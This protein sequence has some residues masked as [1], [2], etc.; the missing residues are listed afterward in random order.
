MILSEIIKNSNCKV[1]QGT[2]D[3]EIQAIQHHSGKI[4]KDTLFVA[5]SGYQR[6]GHDFIGQVITDGATAVVVEKSIDLNLIPDDVSVLEVADTKLALAEMANL[7]YQK[8]TEK[9]NVVGI[10]GTNGKTSITQMLNDLYKTTGQKNAVFGTIANFIGEEKIP[11][12]NTTPDALELARLMSE[13]VKMSCENCFMEVS[14]HALKMG[15]VHNMNFNYAIFTNLTEDHL[16][17]HTDFEDYF[18]AKFQLFKMALKGCVVNNDNEYGRRIIEAMKSH[19]RCLS[20]GFSETA[21]LRADQ[22]EYHQWGSTFHLN[23]H[24]QCVPVKLNIPG[25]IYIYNLMACV[26][27]MLLEGFE[28]DAISKLVTKVKPVRGRLEQVSSDPARTVL[29]DYAH[30]PDALENVLQA[31]HE[32]SKGRIIIVFGCGGDRDRKKRPMMGEVAQRLSDLVILTSDNPRTEAPELIIKDVLEGMTLSDA[33]F[34]EADRRKGIYKALELAGENDVVLIAGKGHEDY[35]V[36]GKTK[37]HFD[38]KEVVQDFF[39]G[40]K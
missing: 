23:W 21:E 17:F 40:R 27:I 26:G 13:A 19:K 22:I 1:I 36:I 14:S 12:V 6:D 3:K 7:F 20:Y 8:P 9:I 39:D 33:L 35:Q 28:L 11:T 24:E 38:D 4:E 18:T 5:I 34:V 32:F 31:I 2:I 30:T 15:R 37:I 10:T 25:K 16:D 29:L